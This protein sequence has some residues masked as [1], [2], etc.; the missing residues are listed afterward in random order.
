MDN[1]YLK[2]VPVISSNCAFSD[3]DGE[4]VVLNIETGK[5]FKLNF[6]GSKV[7]NLMVD[8]RNIE[9]IVDIIAK[10]YDCSSDTIKQD[11]QAFINQCKDFDLVKLN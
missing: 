7:F 5:Y 10:D 9:S 11:I 8:K 1:I 4:K 2:K 3:H 6:I